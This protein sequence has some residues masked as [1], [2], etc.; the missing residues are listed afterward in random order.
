MPEVSFA[1]VSCRKLNDLE[2]RAEELDKRRTEKS[3]ISSVS[4]I[5]DRNRKNNVLKAEMAIQEEMRRKELEGQEANPFTRRKCNPRMVTKNNADVTP[6]M[7]KELAEREERGKME[8][9]NK[10][11]APATADPAATKRKL[12][13]E[14]G[15]AAAGENGK[16]G[17]SKKHK[18]DG[19]KED[20]FSAHDFDIEIDVDMSAVTSSSV[21]AGPA[22]VKA[23]I[24]GGS[25][26]G[27]GVGS[28]GVGRP[29][30][31]PTK[32]SLNLSD[33]KKKRGLI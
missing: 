18:S 11:S 26:G 20:L 1:F 3:S 2:Q 6:E 24:G 12:G 33:Y 23:P 13:G 9:E 8:K 28:S 4:F 27:L 19:A 22:P 16:H 29:G 30:S 21:V 10:T 5:N 32:R 31:G 17:G 25:G 7:L 14:E 15:A